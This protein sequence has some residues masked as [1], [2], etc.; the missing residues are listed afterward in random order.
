MKN[1][2]LVL[3]FVLCEISKKK[4]KPQDFKLVNYMWFVWLCKIFFNQNFACSGR[5]RLKLVYTKIF[6]RKL[7]RVIYFYVRQLFRN[8]SDL[9][10]KSKF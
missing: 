6:R 5:Q 1:R 3:R 8:Y 7:T 2:L 9:E 4:L 10:S